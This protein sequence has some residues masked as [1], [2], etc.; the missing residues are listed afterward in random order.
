MLIPIH[1]P[2][3]DPV[4]RRGERLVRYGGMLPLVAV[5]AYIVIGGIVGQLLN[6]DKDLWQNIHY[7]W[8][9]VV[10]GLGQIAIWLGMYFVQRSR[11]WESNVLTYFWVGG[12]VNTIA[13][14][15]LFV[16]GLLWI[17]WVAPVVATI[18]KRRSVKRRMD[19]EGEAAA[20]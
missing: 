20:S 17:P 7:T 14:V 1:N 4:L 8:V 5:L 18:A 12:I 3:D 16:M 13:V 10:V 19:L 9:S 11:G 15:Q 2:D 6:V